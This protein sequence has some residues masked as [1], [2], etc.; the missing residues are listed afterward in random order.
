MTRRRETISDERRQ[1][2]IDGALKVFSTRG[3]VQAT[4]KDIAEA[5][6]INSAGLIYHYFADKADLLRAVI[7]RYGP[8]MQLMAHSE[9]FMA[10]PLEEA[11]TQ[12]GLTYLRLTEDS[13]A[14]ACMKVLFAEA[15][16]NPEF[17]RIL[18][19][20]GP[21][22]VWQLLADYLARKMEAG[23]L[24]R[25]DPAIAARCFIG[26]LV[27]QLLSRKIFN[28]EDGMKVDSAALVATNVDIFLSG[29]RQEP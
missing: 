10:L 13:H 3:F 1:Q 18:G 6:G 29:L 8:P 15:M 5:A 14:G 22:R 16:H 23:L 19:E 7:E 24:R 27:L 9:Q 20:A 11:L 17:A 28:F 2:I 26:P 25:V 12:F 4:N 21:L